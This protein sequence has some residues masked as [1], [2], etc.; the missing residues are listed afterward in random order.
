MNKI[1]QND[2]VFYTL[3]WSKLYKY[4]KYSAMKILPELSGI[5]SVFKK[6]EN[7][8]VNQLFYGCWRDGCRIGLSKLLDPLFT[9]LS[10]VLEKMGNENIYYRYTI[11]D[12]S[13][14][15]MKDIL[16]WLMNTY[17]TKFNNPENYKDSRRYRS[18]NVDEKKLDPNSVVE[19]LPSRRF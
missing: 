3:A 16:W 15:D 8:D 11:I 13:P 4:E 12:S 14:K 6:K 9:P 19:R 18:I 1:I 2:E 7:T 17:E 5:V 10:H